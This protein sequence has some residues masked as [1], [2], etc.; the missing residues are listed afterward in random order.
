MSNKSNK[1]NKFWS[2][3]KETVISPG[4]AIQAIENNDLTTFKQLVPSSI[5]P[6]AKSSTGRTLLQIAKYLK[7]DNFVDY[8]NSLESESESASTLEAY[9]AKEHK[10]KKF[11]DDFNPLVSEDDMLQ[12][13]IGYV[14]EAIEKGDI[15]TFKRFV[16]SKVPPTA[17][18][19]G[20]GGQRRTIRE[21]AKYH[22]KLRKSD[23]FV[24]YLDTLVKGGGKVRNPYTGRMIQKG[25]ALA[26][27]LGL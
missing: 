11:V 18:S 7:R 4:Y 2:N 16:P 26:R 20:H 17:L 8:L 25:G 10:S 23:D 27:R 3:L 1:S 14:I 24:G 9:Q 15:K 21:I 22:D 5:E 19:A 12:T 6:T 13:Q